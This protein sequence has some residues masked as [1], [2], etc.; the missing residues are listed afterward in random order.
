MRFLAVPAV[1]LTALSLVAC[2]AG[3]KPTVS[4]GPGPVLSFTAPRMDATFQ[5]VKKKV[6]QATKDKDGKDVTDKD[7]KI[8]EAEVEV[9][10]LPKVEVLFDL[11]NYAIGKV[12]AGG[13]GQHIHLILDN[14]PYQAIYD[15][16]T[17]TVLDPAKLPALTKGTHILR[18]F[19]SAGPNDAKGAYEHEARK[20]DGAFAW[21]RFHVGEKGGDLALDFDPAKPML[22]YSRPKGE[23]VVGTVNQKNFM[24]DWYQTN[25]KLEAGG[26]HVAAWLDGKRLDEFDVPKKGEGGKPIPVL[27]ADKKP[28]LNADG[29]P[30]HEMAKE[31]GYREWKPVIVPAPGVGEHVMKLELHDRDDKLVPGPFNSTERKFTVV[32][33]K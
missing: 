20:G 17:A 11:M 23:Y 4:G 32:E 22:T 14:E 27:D 12:D 26:V 10:V 30:K 15:I 1:V 31:Y 7:G 29:S 5:I 28:V 6:K 13:N 25:V 3:T 16:T 33:K 9:E 18:A 21:V 8:V 2:D 19:P 24:L